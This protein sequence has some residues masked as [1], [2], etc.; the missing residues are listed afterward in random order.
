MQRS[1]T[2]VNTGL[3]ITVAGRV[4]PAMGLLFAY[5][6]YFGD[7]NKSVPEQFADDGMRQHDMTDSI[8]RDS[9]SSLYSNP[10]INFATKYTL[11][12]FLFS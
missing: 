6:R 9:A 4:I 5:Y 10:V 1:P 8:I 12:N 3:V 2:L 11:A 7:P